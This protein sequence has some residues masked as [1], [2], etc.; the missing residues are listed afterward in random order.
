MN[1]LQEPIDFLKKDELKNIDLSQMDKKERYKIWKRIPKCELHCHLDLCF[2]ADFF[3]SCVRK[4]NLQ[5]NLS[6]EE[7]LDYYLFAKGG[8]SLGEFVEKAIRVADIFQDYEMIEDLAKHAVFNKYKEGVVLMEFRYSPT[9]VAFKHNLDIELIHQAI[10]KGIKEVVELL[11]HKI[12]VTLLCIGDTGHRAADIKASADFC[13][14][15]KADFVGFDHGGHEVDLKP[16]K[17]IFDYVKEG[18]MHLTVHAGEDVTLPNLNT[19]YSAIQVLKVERIGHGI[20]V[21]ESQELIDMVKENNILLEVCPI[22]NV[23]LKN[24]KSFDTHPIRKLYDA[25]VK[26]SVSS[27]DPGMFLTNINDDYEKLYTHLHFTLE[28]FMKMNEWALEKSFIGCDI[29]EKIKKLYF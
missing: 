10:V 15:H 5:P 3:L 9:F 27:D 8:K 4:Y 23:L 2:S 21:S 12:D 17:E 18:G 26:V 19:L 1:I 29:K 24:A 7:V 6:D 25:G 20:R 14:K 22:S 28:D 16:Y 11:D 13:L